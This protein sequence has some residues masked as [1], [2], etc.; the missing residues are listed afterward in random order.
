ML[1]AGVDLAAEPAKTAV[2][3]IRWDGGDARL[4]SL[5]LGAGDSAI[6]SIAERVD[7][8][9]IDCAFG[10]PDEFVEFVRRH[11]EG[12]RVDL[13]EDVGLPWRRRL[14]YRETDREVQRITGR[15]P[16]SVATDRLGLTAMRCAALL[17]AIADRIGMVD[18]SG[19]GR[20]VE[21]YPAAAL[22]LWRLDATGYKKEQL[23]RERLLGDLQHVAPWLDLDDYSEMMITSDDAF[24]AVVAALVTRARAVD[25]VH[26]IPDEH[27]NRAR[28]EGW[29]ALPLGPIGDLRG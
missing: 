6:A 25:R 5:Q 27:R 15:A 16:L 18:R 13:S 12:H 21:V 1:T 23:A 24:D 8:I 4:E 19:Q 26:L 3:V 14:A 22:R 2:S 11:A 7:L 9:G 10:W 20:V 29:I 28:R 17:D